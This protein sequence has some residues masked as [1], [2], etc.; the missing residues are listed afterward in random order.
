ME[1]IT[2]SKQEWIFLILLV[3]PF[4]YSAIIWN[5][6]PES[7]PTHFNIHGEADRYSSKA[8]G[9]F[10]FPAL[11]VVLYFVL[12]YIPNIDP[13]KKNYE[14]FGK[15]YENIRL[16]IA[17]FILI[18][19]FILMQA[20]LG[21]SVLVQ[22]RFI[23][24][25]V[26]LLFAMLGNYMRNIRPNFFVGIRTPWTL[27]SP[28]VWRKTHELGGKIW[29]YGGLTGVLLS[30]ILPQNDLPYLSITMIIILTLIP[31]VYSYAEFQK[32]KKQEKN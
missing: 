4:V 11:A 25:A 2:R 29:F 19:Y 30:F 8:F 31:V 32:I 20:A 28:E 9:A 23:F 5:R 22:P 21:N 26:F 15:S 3:I 1:K 17:V 10:G 12:R 16:V 13:R 7:V 27:D 18:I 6:L 24:S 14:Y